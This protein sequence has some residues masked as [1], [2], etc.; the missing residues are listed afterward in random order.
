MT[1]KDGVLFLIGPDF[2]RYLISIGHGNSPVGS[3]TA[4]VA[5]SSGDTLSSVHLYSSGN[6]H[7]QILIRH[8]L[9]FEDCKSA[10]HDGASRIVGQ[11]VFLSNISL[12]I[13]AELLQSF[14]RKLIELIAGSSSQNAL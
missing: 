14:G 8:K 10:D 7:H 2:Q 3:S 4:S 5:I 9:N 13:S 6:Q 11:P 12:A 1:S